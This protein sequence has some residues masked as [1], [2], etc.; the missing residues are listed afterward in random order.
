MCVHAETLVL[1]VLRGSDTQIN[2]MTLD[3]ILTDALN[4]GNM[5]TITSQDTNPSSPTKDSLHIIITS[6][7][8]LLLISLCIRWNAT[9]ASVE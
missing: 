8:S 2:G 1:L 9:L 5:T 4:F 7:D 6:G 3:L